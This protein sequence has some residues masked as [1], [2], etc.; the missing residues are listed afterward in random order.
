MNL[1][2]QKVKHSFFGLGLVKSVENKRI[3]IAFSENVGVKSFKYPDAFANYLEMC[4]A[5]VQCSVLE[6]LSVILAQLENEK[7]E[8]ERV[9]QEAQ[10]KV[11]AE[12]SA[13]RKAAAKK[14]V[15]KK[16][17]PKA[18]VKKASVDKI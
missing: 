14:P 12:R 11:L 2:D 6:D 13:L 15:K 7:V 1:I 4:D 8:K 5:D 18:K 10:E 3:A 9:Y 17:E 16:A